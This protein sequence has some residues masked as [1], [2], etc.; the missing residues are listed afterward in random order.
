M[1][2][3]QD[4]VFA[5]EDMD[6]FLSDDQVV[7]S[8]DKDDDYDEPPKTR[9]R[10][11][12]TRA[13]TTRGRGRKTTRAKSTTEAPKQTR[14]RRRT[15][16]E[17]KTSTMATPDAAESGE[18]QDNEM[19]KK[20]KG[21]QRKKAE[22]A[23]GKKS[24]EPMPRKYDPEAIQSLAQK[25]PDIYWNE[26][27]APCSK[28]IQTIDE[29]HPVSLLKVD[30]RDQGAITGMILSPDGNM[31]ATC[32][33]LGSVKL[34]DLDSFQLIQ[35][36]RDAQE[37]HIDEFYVGKFTPEQDRLIV[38]GKLKDRLRWSEADDD[39]HILPCP[40]KIFDVVESTVVGKLEGHSEE[41]LCIKRLQF[42]GENYVVSTSQDGYI[43][44][45]KLD[46]DW[47]TLL[48]K[49]VVEDGITCMAFTVS[50]L[51]HTGN[52]YFLGACDDHIKLYDFE[53]G[54]LL[55]TFENIYSSYCD[56]GK[57]IEC[58]EIPIPGKNE[59]E[60]SQQTILTTSD[61]LARPADLPTR[62]FAYFLSR[63]VE[64]LD[65]EDNTISSCPNTCTLHRLL[66]PDAKHDNF[67]LEE[68]RRY[69]HEDYMSNSWL[70]KVA[71]NG[72]YFCAPTLNGQTFVFHLATGKLA[73]ILKG[74]EEIEVRD[75]IFHPTRNLL[76]TSADDGC[77]KVYS[78]TPDQ[79]MTE[80]E[81]YLQNITTAIPTDI[82]SSPQ[83][84][85]LSADVTTPPDS[86]A[87]HPP[88]SP[89]NDETSEATAEIEIIVDI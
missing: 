43:I 58:L 9:G 49:T 32:C 34:W 28:R 26:L 13:G 72:R 67:E 42:R 85:H 65:A 70:I 82:S 27:Y 16:P 40:L 47:C 7:E 30:I 33:N 89:S 44:R 50:F 51:P 76:F 36:L 68:I 71:S 53:Q 73:A 14:R 59:A 18:S 45:W 80:I 46:T 15:T 55:Q 25:Y 12:A 38:G 75:V 61:E 17:P 10:K 81:V 20:T 1:L 4:T 54:R 87:P 8:D 84:K 48:E 62:P 56:C 64:L 41:V 31:L 22:T 52:K 5:G 2:S 19:T 21:R 83:G 88:S 35:K 57:F 63:G 23:R 86:T 66:Y 6:M 3:Q 77:V 79:I 60:K 39:N 78:Q 11:N 69:H 74:H 37:P 29:H 24:V